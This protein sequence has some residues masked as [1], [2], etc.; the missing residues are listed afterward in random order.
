MALD[1]LAIAYVFAIGRRLGG[2]ICGVLA[3]ALLF[4]GQRTDVLQNVA[5][6]GVAPAALLTCAGGLYH[7]LAWR[8]VNPDVKRH[9]YAMA[10]WFVFGMMTV[11]TAAVLLAALLGA[12]AL[13]RRADQVRLYRDWQTFAIAAGLALILLWLLT[14]YA[15]YLPFTSVFSESTHI[16]GSSSTLRGFV[17]SFSSNGVDGPCARTVVRAS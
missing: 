10:L 3:A 11:P 5:G 2:L 4:I 9:V 12:A 16:P 8:S 7:F 13:A 15:A 1:A 6:G 14:R 17:G